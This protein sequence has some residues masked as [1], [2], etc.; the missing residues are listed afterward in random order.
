MRSRYEPLPETELT[1]MVDIIFQLMIFFLV[2]LSVMPSIK[3]APQVEGMMNLPTPKKG[4]SEASVL[5]QFHKTPQ[6]GIDYYVLQGDDQSAKFYT[7][8]QDKRS[9]VAIPSAYIAFRNAV[10][11]YGVL[12]NQQTLKG[13]LNEIWVNDP[14]VIIRAPGNLPYGE[15]VKVTGY[16]YALGISKIAWV[17]GTL[18][19]MKVEI[20][21]SRARRQG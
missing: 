17:K 15:V 11:R 16:M 2:T 14:A 18:A 4:N 21:K 19:D 9:V 1:S 13:L 3:S 20:K 5:I 8:F 10:Q 6:G 7:W 12:Y